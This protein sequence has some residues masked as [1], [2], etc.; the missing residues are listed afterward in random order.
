MSLVLAAQKLG[1]SADTGRSAA[2]R[3]L[4]GS[5]PAVRLRNVQKRRPQLRDTQLGSESVAKVSVTGPRISLT[6]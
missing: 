2:T 4:F 3:R 1:A 5:L 6:V